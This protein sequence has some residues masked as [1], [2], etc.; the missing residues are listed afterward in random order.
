MGM[1]FEAAK[2]RKEFAIQAYILTRRLVEIR[3]KGNDY[4]RGIVL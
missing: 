4:G 2:Y 1:H 3:Y